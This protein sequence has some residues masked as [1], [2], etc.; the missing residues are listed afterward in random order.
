VPVH[1]RE[2]E[3]DDVHVLGD[4][5]ALRTLFDPLRLRIMGAIR[6]PR[7]AKEIAAALG[8]EPNKLYYHLRRLQDHGLVSVD[9]RG[10]GAER[11]FAATA[12][13]LAI[14]P[15]VEPSAV[16]ASAFVG[17]LFGEAQRQIEGLINRRSTE[18]GTGGTVSISQ[19]SATLSPAKLAR[20]Q[21]RLRKLVSD[22]DAEPVSMSKAAVEHSLLVTLFATPSSS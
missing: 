16:E 10:A 4:V 1:N 6:T 19:V 3:P 7:T 5:A 14:D 11:R 9:D 15:A 13:R 2:D 20:Y 8:V 21:E 18:A 17:A 12:R 22:F